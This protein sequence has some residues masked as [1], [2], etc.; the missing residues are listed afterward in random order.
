[1]DFLKSIGGKIVTGL[2]ALGV[3]ASLIAWFQMDQVTRNHIEAD[4]GRILAWLGIV[5][6]LPWVTFFATTA[7]AKQESNLTG[8]L[9]VIGYTIVEAVILA[10]LFGWHLHGAMTVVFFSGAV[11]LAGA[12]NLFTCDW[13]AEKL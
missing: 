2:V 10:W 1:M 13:I 3:V 12:Y 11:L 5:L 9:L 7:I 8:A 6:L 4:T